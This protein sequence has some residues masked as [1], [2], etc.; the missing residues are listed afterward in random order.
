MISIQATGSSFSRDRRNADEVYGV[1]SWVRA[2]SE[3]VTLLETPIRAPRANA[4]AERCI[5]TAL[6][7][8][9]AC[10]EQGLFRLR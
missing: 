1:R 8:A 3:G 7:A 6:V 4:F 2:A 9:F 10:C 5:R